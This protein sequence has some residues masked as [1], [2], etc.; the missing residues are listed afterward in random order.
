MPRLPQ[1]ALQNSV[2]VLSGAAGGIGSAIALNLARRGCHLALCDIK[3]DALA[4]TAAACRACGITVSEHVFD[5]ADAEAIAAVPD[6][7]QASHGR[8][9]ILI[10]CAGVALG[11]RFNQVSVEEFEWLFEIN[12]LS[13]VRMTKAFLPLLESEPQAQI[14]NLSSVLGLIGAA[15]QCAYS[16]SKFAI[17]GLSEALGNEFEMLGKNIGVSVVYVG[18]VRTGM[19]KN[20]RAAAVL[21]LADVERLQGIWQ[22]LLRIPP[23]PVAEA[24]VSGLERRKVRILCGVDAT[25]VDLVQRLMPTRYWALFRNL[26]YLK[27][28]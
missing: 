14:V 25:R 24:I 1:L 9:N 7:V 17:R 28:I 15:G 26:P 13:V 18:G 11:G 10:N 5:V 27:D 21:P 22:N 2:A 12:F 16:A 19:A 6:A 23:E 20:A 4:Q 8:V 3:S